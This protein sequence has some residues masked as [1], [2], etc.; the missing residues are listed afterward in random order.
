MRR[1]RALDR[2]LFAGLVGAYL[3]VLGLTIREWRFGSWW[4]PFSVSGAPSAVG[5]PVV[6]RLN[7][8]DLPV[9]VGDAVL[10]LAGVDLRGLS[11]SQ[12]LHATA[13][14]V[15]EGRSFSL[16][17]E[18][19][20][21]RLELSIEPLADPTSWWH[22]AVVASA[23][24]A[25]GLLLFRA[26]HWHLSRRFFV[27]SLLWCMFQ[28][29]DLG[30][31]NP[32]LV[33]VVAL[34]APLWLGLIVWCAFEWTESA[35]PLPR[36]LR[37][38]PWLL[39]LSSAATYVAWQLLVHPLSRIAQQGWMLVLAAVGATTLAGLARAYLR[40]GPLE[41]RQLRWILYGAFVA[42]LPAIVVT[43]AVALG[44]EFDYLIAQEVSLIF[45]IALPLGIVVS[46]VGYRWLDVDRLI[47]ATASY[48]LVGIAL[49]AG[50]LAGVPRLAAA[51]SP[52]MGVDPA[53]GQLVLSLALAGV[54]VPLQRALRPWIDRRLFA[55]RYALSQASEALSNELAG[56]RSVEELATLSGE[57]IDTLLRP[58]S[59][60]TYARSGE[61]FVPIAV[62]GRGAPPA[63]EAAS[64]LVR[65]LEA[66]SVP[67]SAR[68]KQLGAFDRASLET[69]GVEVVVP[70]R[71]GDELVAFTCLGGKRS[72]DIYTPT[73]VA[74]L[75]TL[76]NRC[77]EVLARLDAES[78]ARESQAMQTAL[79]RYVPGAIVDRVRTGSGLEPAERE[80]T[81]L[82]V[83]LRDYTRYADQ[84]TA[85]DVFAALNEHTERASAIVQACGGA[86][87]EFHG[88]G[89]MA[90]FGAPEALERKELHA[91]EA[92]RRIVDSMPAHLAV[93][94][95]IA[96][97]LAFVGSIR[98]VDRLIWTAVGSTTNLAARLQ[99][100]TRELGAA[101]AV[102]ET[103]R[104][105]A[106]YV[107]SDFE[108]HADVAIRGRSER[109]DVFALPLRESARV[110]TQP[111]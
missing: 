2:L 12:A 103:T 91:V 5:H 94:V 78:V 24:A 87:V 20:G 104:E 65:V 64:L 60:A 4:F 34:C 77:A 8:A 84:R 25:G 51:T 29:A 86:V 11:R 53:T 62:R 109:Q 54:L 71:R 30:V 110:T 22:L 26:P 81:I 42:I 33:W 27:A 79:R 66:R 99:A 41:R 46:V 44:A 100:L 32:Y 89:M 6:D 37:T 68:A 55:E 69:L 18:R 73:D 10:R 59:I 90:V 102:D 23:G 31:S 111:A 49:V 40:S 47:S 61:S 36:G 15:R 92:G 3:G 108:R 96:T 56:C 106:G 48:T 17:V 21:R 98:S 76:A 1:S 9:R 14:I 35:R 19:D 107:C 13:P 72:G 93:G 63:I 101:L 50:V 97:G 43:L 82:F 39:G 52:A 57:G 70:I 88:D 67:L 95:G 16:E 85:A 45:T 80:V 74:L 58:E 38:L 7:A 28:T 105:R 83:D 75:A